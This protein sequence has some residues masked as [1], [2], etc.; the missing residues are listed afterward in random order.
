MSYYDL[1]P[2]S[3]YAEIGQKIY[4][5]A[6]YDRKGFHEFV[7]EIEGDIWQ[8]IFEAIGYSA[9]QQVTVKDI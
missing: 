9:M 1:K 5:D 4:Q 7:D 8:G 6:L 3:R 2:R